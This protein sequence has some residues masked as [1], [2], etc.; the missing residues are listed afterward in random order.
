MSRVRFK[1]GL[2][3]WLDKR[4]YVIKKRLNNYDF[5][6][7][8]VI[9]ENLTSISEEALCHLFF[10]E[11]LE[12][13]SPKNIDNS[14]KKKDYK[15]SEFAYINENDKEVAKRRFKYVQC[16][17]DLGLQKRTQ[18]SLIPVI[19]KISQ[20]IQDTQP[21]SCSTLYRWIKK[22]EEND[23]DIRSLVPRHIA[24][25][26]YRPDLDPEVSKIIDEVIS[27]FYLT[28]EKPSIADSCSEIIYRIAKENLIRETL[29]LEQ[30]N[31][32]HRSTI[33]RKF[34]EIDSYEETVGRFGKKMAERL[35]NSSQNVS[36]RPT[37]PLEVVEI[38]HT[39]LPVFV[40][41]PKTGLPIGTPSLTVAIDKYTGIPIGYYLG[42]EPFSSISVMHCLRHAITP[43]DYIS[44]KFPSVNNTW[45]PYGLMELVKVDNGLE[46]HGKQLEDACLQLGILI[47]YTPPRTPWYKGTIERYFRTQA[48]NLLQGL[49]GSFSKFLKEFDDEYDPQKNSVITIDLLHEIIHI[50]IVD[51]LSQKS[52]P[53]FG[54]PRAEVW[55]TAIAQFPPALPKSL[56]ELQV[57]L[58]AIAHRVISKD[59]VEL[60]GLFYRSSELS[61]LRSIYQ[62]RDRR[63][64]SG[65]REKEKAI[66][67]YDPTDVSTIYVFDPEK[68]EFVPFFAVAQEYTKGLSFW[69]HQAIKRLASKE[70]EKVDHI[71]LAIA[72]KKTQE[73]LAESL[74]SAKKGKPMVLI[75]RF[76]NSGQDGINVEDVEKF[77][78]R[79]CAKTAGSLNNSDDKAIIA[80][81]PDSS[82]LAGI[83]NSSSDLKQAENPCGDETLSDSL[84]SH[85]LSDNFVENDPA[86]IF[87][88]S[89]IEVARNS[90]KKS[91]KTSNKKSKKLSSHSDENLTNTENK[92]TRK[93]EDINSENTGLSFSEDFELDLSGWSA[94]YELPK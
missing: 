18:E 50:F 30:L 81:L 2:N 22:Y 72:K 45:H 93:S 60:G 87:T 88:Q 36:Q 76:F 28:L 56:K 94:S 48:S 29:G 61:R 43:K 92:E 42:F 38:D 83:S 57:L 31:V 25:G 64:Q 13:V 24:K 84:I 91:R 74:K 8:D 26:D 65:S 40:I 54:T 85:A 14:E 58:G 90:S 66:I 49:P 16:Y 55:K 7:C 77:H 23:N 62:E 82:F 39:K 41:D 35:Y 75:T 89:N 80:V 6:I 3:F 1:Q 46:F 21:P 79:Q 37:R 53:D 44:K 63:R 4:E 71:A 15:L 11:R 32:P 86:E 5:Q 10:I 68:H 70:S 78:E 12:F 67:K 9:T 47:Q 27:E 34:K 73:I 20:E 59:G 51:I 17:F 19:E 33:Y 69:Q 52:H